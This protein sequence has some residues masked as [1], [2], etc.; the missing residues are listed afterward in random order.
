MNRLKKIVVEV[1]ETVVL[2]S[3]EFKIVNFC[4]GC[5]ERTE[6]A[7]PWIAATLYGTSEREVFRLVESRDV[8]TIEE[9]RTLV[10]LACVRKA[11]SRRADH[12]EAV[13]IKPIGILEKP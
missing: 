13:L 7:T 12:I 1:E 5:E 3:G 11:L 9:E 8:H 2:R 4:P 6:L 10:C